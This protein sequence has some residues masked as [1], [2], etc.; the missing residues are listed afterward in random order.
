MWFAGVDLSSS[1]KKPT[2]VALLD[3]NL[4]AKV[5]EL[6]TDEE[7]LEAVSSARPMYTGIDAPLSLP[8]KS[9]IRGCEKVLISLGIRF[10]PPTMPSMLS[11]TLRGMRLR[12]QLKEA[13]LSILEVYPGGSQDVLCLPRS[14]R[15]LA[16]LEHGLRALGVKLPVGR[17][18][19]DALDAVTAAYTAFLYWRGDCLR[20]A[21]EDCSLVLPIPR[22]LPR[23][24]TRRH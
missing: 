12:M 9:R 1:E 16:G 18:T 4:T 8:S 19:G 22:C 14:K 13:G 10:F 7:I 2:Y 20:L 17:L 15:S 21:S 6:S 11:L 5:F 24:P 23:I 3:E